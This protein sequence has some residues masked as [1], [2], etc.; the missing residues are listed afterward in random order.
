MP[1]PAPHTS[2]SRL[3]TPGEVW[4]AGRL[5]LVRGSWRLSNAATHITLHWPEGTPDTLHER[6]LARVHATWTGAHLEVHTC[7]IIPVH[8]RRTPGH[9]SHTS[10]YVMRQRAA[11]VSRLRRFFEARD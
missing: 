11:C 3:D 7:D 5:K 8:D 6:D 1:T 9:M 10:S 4:T 2:L